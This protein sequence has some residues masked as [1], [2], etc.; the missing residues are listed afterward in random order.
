M[1]LM[2]LLFS[3]LFKHHQAHEMNRNHYN[4]NSRGYLLQRCKV[5]VLKVA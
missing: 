2:L 5:G 1:L 3:P 4:H